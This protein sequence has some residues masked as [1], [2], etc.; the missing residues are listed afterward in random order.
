M[1]NV[2]IFMSTRVG[3]CFFVWHNGIALN[4]LEC[5]MEVVVEFS[6]AMT[7]RLW[8]LIFLTRLSGRQVIIGA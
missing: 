8:N 1:T 7:S 2:E 4:C 6:V 3:S 5:Y